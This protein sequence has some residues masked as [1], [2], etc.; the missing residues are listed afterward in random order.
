[1]RD[2]GERLSVGETAA[3]FKALDSNEDNVVD[4]HEFSS[5]MLK[6]ILVCGSC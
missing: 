5:G 3:Y 2:M 4:F 1:M 6:Y